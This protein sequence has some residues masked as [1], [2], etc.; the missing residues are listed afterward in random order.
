MKEEIQKWTEQYQHGGLELAPVIADGAEPVQ[1][2]DGPLE[3]CKTVLA[4][5]RTGK[6][7]A[8]TDNRERVEIAGMLLMLAVEVGANTSGVPESLFV[9]WANDI[10]VTYPKLTVEELPMAFGM[11]NVTDSGIQ[12][13]GAFSGVYV[14]NLVKHYW[15]ESR[16][17]MAKAM[18]FEPVPEPE[19]KALPLP[20]GRE[21]AKAHYLTWKNDSGHLTR[22]DWV[23]GCAEALAYHG[24]PGGSLTTDMIHRAYGLAVRQVLSGRN[25]IGIHKPI[26]DEFKTWAVN[27]WSYFR[28]DVAEMGRV[29]SAARVKLCQI[30]YSEL[31][32]KEETNG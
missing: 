20:D 14:L 26:G 15:N 13:Y 19:I 16:K 6:K 29:A 5:R 30:L 7:L 24:R 23:F 2:Y 32:E 31:R 10:C 25:L 18:S 27:P 12:H 17:A 8:D 28:G 3:Y 4:A 9:K 11:K 1:L 22:P 21:Y